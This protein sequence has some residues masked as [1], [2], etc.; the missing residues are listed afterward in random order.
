M[1]QL[2]HIIVA[3]VCVI[4]GIAAIINVN[5]NFQHTAKIDQ[6]KQALDKFIFE[7][8]QMCSSNSF[9]EVTM[10]V[11]V[12]TGSIFYI[13]NNK[14]CYRFEEI[15]KCNH[16]NCDTQEG[17]LLNLSDN[18]AKSAFSSIDIKCN[19]KKENKIIITCS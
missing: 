11:R 16:C 13:K 8:D 14:V 17:V 3:V 19:I 6:S 18:I 10:T 1:E 2:M 9:Q 15:V 12:P 5:A 7:C 4:I